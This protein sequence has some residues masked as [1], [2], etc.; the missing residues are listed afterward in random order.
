MN[1]SARDEMMR[2]AADVIGGAGS[3]DGEYVNKVLWSIRQIRHAN[4]TSPLLAFEARIIDGALKPS[5]DGKDK[6]RAVEIAHHLACY[7]GD[8]LNMRQHNRHDTIFARV[9]D[10]LEENN[11]LLKIG[12]GRSNT[13]HES[14]G[15]LRDLAKAV[16]QA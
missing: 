7:E 1:K 16:E 15:A 9:A 3:L 14:I 13:I 6:A 11:R 12:R 5:D 2:R 8:S 10:A 4:E